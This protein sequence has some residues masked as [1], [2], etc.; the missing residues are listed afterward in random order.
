MEH[1]LAL[2]SWREVEEYLSRS[3]LVLIPVGS[4]EQHGPNGLIG[5]DAI[6]AETIAREAGQRLGALVAPTVSYG[7][8]LHHMVFPGTVSL[9]P[10]TLIA[11][12]HDLVT[13]LFAHGF[14]EFLFVNGHGG[15]TASGAA[16][17]SGL[18]EEFPDARMRWVSWWLDSGV[19]ACGQR[20]FGDRNGSHASPSEISVSMVAHPD[21]VRP[22]D[23]PLDVEI[24]RPRGI[25]GSRAFRTLYPDGRIGS[26]PSL[27]RRQHGEAL[28]EVAVDAVCREARSLAVPAHE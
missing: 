10:E 9:R 7:M 28:L 20:L 18:A 1:R 25:P 19:A 8:S 17:M 27:A 21:A 16:A 23:G 26:D 22:L 15:N 6:C 3:Q 12:I 13:S 24:C 14:R 4:T 5:T 2:L 11:V